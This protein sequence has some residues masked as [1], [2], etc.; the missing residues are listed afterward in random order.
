MIME[1]IFLDEKSKLFCKSNLNCFQFVSE[2]NALNFGSVKI[3][4]DLNLLLCIE[5]TSK[6]RHAHSI[7]EYILCRQQ[8]QQQQQQQQLQLTGPVINDGWFFSLAS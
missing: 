5:Y 6:H 1:T 8:Q 3:L 7:N 2:L 4:W